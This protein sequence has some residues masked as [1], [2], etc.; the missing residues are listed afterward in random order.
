VEANSEVL[1]IGTQVFVVVNK[2]KTLINDSGTVMMPAMINA[3]KGSDASNKD[4]E[5]ISAHEQEYSDDEQEQ[6]A[7]RERKQNK[8]GRQTDD[9]GGGAGGGKGKGKARGGGKG[10]GKGRGAASSDLESNG[11]NAESTLACNDYRGR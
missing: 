7:K 8:R 5:E 2:A 9:G 6:A 1:K 10:K 4:D 11:G 3:S